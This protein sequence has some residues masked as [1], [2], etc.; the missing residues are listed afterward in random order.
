M[1]KNYYDTSRSEDV[2]IKLSRHPQHSEK[3]FHYI[4]NA[5]I[6]NSFLLDLVNKT[7]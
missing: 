2:V 7:V 5:Q 4:L 6:V 3:S 1:P